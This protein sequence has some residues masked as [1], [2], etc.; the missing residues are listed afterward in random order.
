MRQRVVLGIWIVAGLLLSFS[1]RLAAASGSEGAAFLNI[2]L[3]GAPSAMGSAYSALATDVYAP[4]INPGGLGFVESPQLAGHHVS[5][6]ESSHYDFASLVFPLAGR[7]ALGASIQ[8]YGS[9]DMIRRD[10]L[11]DAKGDFSAYYGAFTLSYGR[12]LNEKLS[13]GASGRFLNA[14]IDDVSAYGFAADVGTLYKF[15]PNL[16][17]SLV[18]RNAG[19]PL[20]FLNRSDR[21][22]LNVRAG[23][24]WGM[25]REW[26]VSTEGA[27]HEGGLLSGHFGTQWQMHPIIALR[28]GYHT[29]TLDELS[30]IAGVSTGVGL[31]FW[32]TEFSYTWLPYGDLGQT[33]SF[34]LVLRFGEDKTTPRLI[35]NQTASRPREEVFPQ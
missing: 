29:D 21:L 24:A 28:A 12:A 9:G 6:L 16:Q 35:R 23:A 2:P 7:H 14:R 31:N 10:T 34:A 1:P 30:A 32:G 15:A 27:Y 8:Y 4:V 18:V 11:G 20:K 3:G 19:T 25:S 26:T 22:P 13:L 17:G 33:H 5:Y